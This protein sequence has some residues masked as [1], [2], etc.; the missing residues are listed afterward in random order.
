M[1]HALYLRVMGDRT[2]G[3]V[4]LCLSGGGFRAML[5]HAGAVL[6]LIQLGVLGKVSVISAVS[7]GSIF[8]GL[9]A[10]HW[11]ALKS[12]GFSNYRSEILERCLNVATKS[13]DVKAVLIGLQP[14]RTPAQGVAELYL[15]KIW[16]SPTGQRESLFSWDGKP[17]L[18][19]DLR[20]LDGI[21]FEFNAT[22][23][24]DGKRWR[25]SK[26]AIGSESFQ[27]LGVPLASHEIRTKKQGRWAQLLRKIPADLAILFT[28]RD[29]EILEQPREISLAEAIA[30][31]GA[32][33][34]ILS[35]FIVQ[36]SKAD[37]AG[38]KPPSIITDGGVYDNLGIQP[39]MGCE[40]ILVSDGGGVFDEDTFIGLSV[41]FFKNVG[42]PFQLKRVFDVVDARSREQ[43]RQWL[44]DRLAMES[45]PDMPDALK[46][47]YARKTAYWMMDHD[48]RPFETFAAK[49]VRTFWP[50]GDGLRVDPGI[51]RALARV[52]TRLSPMDR[53][54]AM[55]IINLGYARCDSYVRMLCPELLAGGN[56]ACEY[57]FAEVNLNA[58]FDYQPAPRPTHKIRWLYVAG[59]LTL[60][61]LA[62]QALV[63][64]LGGALIFVIVAALVLIATV[65]LLLARLVARQ[66]PVGIPGTHFDLTAQ[67]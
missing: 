17:I 53:R 19:G 48:L 49:D 16:A 21:N 61:V 50:P 56:V 29:G 23:L 42:I 55:Q 31:S 45:D 62:A 43:V 15:R 37:R 27:K 40:T 25:A 2:D 13:I 28:N 10:T 54:L 14:Q 30:S 3:K 34:P 66:P 67:S 44:F 63:A 41:P 46:K 58:T 11:T 38:G 6:R 60:L 57:P 47:R 26:D 52:Q 33:P 65:V 39:A 4:G 51:G 18:L 64:Y 8:A 35:P 24:N 22:L 1:D 36:A 7:G 9:L 12:A 59:L 32:F 20:S 5:F